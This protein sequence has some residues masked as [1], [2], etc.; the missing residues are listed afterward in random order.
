MHVLN[1]HDVGVEDG[2]KVSGSQ[3]GLRPRFI[4][5]C[6]LQIYKKIVD[7]NSINIDKNLHK[8]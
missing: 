5:L 1:F 4:E 8:T 6:R 3:V 7:L 2:R